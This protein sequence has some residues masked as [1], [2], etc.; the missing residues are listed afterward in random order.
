MEDLRVAIG[1]VN[2]RVGQF[3]RNIAKHRDFA[4]RAA[5]AKAKVIVFPETSLSGYPT[6]NGVPLELAQPL[7]GPL[8]KAMAQVSAETGLIILAGMI[9][10]DRSGVVYNTQLVTSPAGVVGGYR[11]VHVGN[12]EIHRFS[13]GDDFT[14][15]PMKEASFGVQICYDNHFPEGSRSLA[16]R[17][18][19]ILFCPYGSPGPCTADGVT[20]KQERWLKY[21][22][23]RAFDNS[24]YIVQVN[25]VGPS[26]PSAPETGSVVGSHASSA[27][28]THVDL[29]EFPG[30][31]LVLN[32]WGE[33]IAKA[34]C[35]EE[36]LIVDLPAATIREKRS[37]ALQFFT[38][39]RRPELYGELVRPSR[40]PSGPGAG[41]SAV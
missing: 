6:T 5:Q 3:E 18:A 37:D 12:S 31:S 21:L 15:F 1:Q 23:A 22:P 7:D 27:R 41:V 38:H 14:V 10:R 11:K 9:E 36:L 2:S 39:F 30:G 8:G 24:V 13:R 33:V 19:E 34:G 20:A 25:Q 4:R 28:D 17:G 16:L 40:A 32:P 26:D 29:P 35:S